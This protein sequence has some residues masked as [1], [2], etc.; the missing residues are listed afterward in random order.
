MI[1]SCPDDHELQREDMFDDNGSLFF[2]GEE[3]TQGRDIRDLA[4]LLSQDI[5]ESVRSRVRVA[6]GM[7]APMWQPTPRRLPLRCF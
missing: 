4:R 6:I 2:E 7:E 5:R 3:A 1:A